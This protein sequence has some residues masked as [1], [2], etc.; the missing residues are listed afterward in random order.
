[1]IGANRAPE[2]AMSIANM[3]KQFVSQS[4]IVPFQTRAVTT[5]QTT[6]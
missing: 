4:L 5:A 6:T 1:M 3:V 2:S